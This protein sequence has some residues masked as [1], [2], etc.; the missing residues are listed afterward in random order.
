MFS[1]AKRS[2]LL[3]Q[4][5]DYVQKW[6]YNTVLFDAIAVCQMSAGQMTINQMTLRQ[7]TIRQMTRK[8]PQPF[9]QITSFHN[10]SFYLWDQ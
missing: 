2:S 9:I 10:T 8:C 3:Y 1:K 4:G 6:F 7:M 5:K